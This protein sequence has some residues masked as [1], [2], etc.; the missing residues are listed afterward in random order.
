MLL[1]ACC[2]PWGALQEQTGHAGHRQARRRQVHLYST[3]G[4]CNTCIG[5]PGRSTW[6]EQLDDAPYSVPV[7]RRARA[8]ARNM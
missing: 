7:P 4:T 3:L 2:W 6:Q 1:P 8:W 5:V